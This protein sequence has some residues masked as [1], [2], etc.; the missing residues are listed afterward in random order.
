MVMKR[1]PSGYGGLLGADFIEYD[2]GKCVVELIVSK[3]HLN[4]GG[5]V[6]GGVING[7]LDIA[8]SAAVTSAMLDKAE[9]VVTLQ[10]NVNF[11]RAGKLGD[12]LITTAEIV[13]MG[14]TIINVEGEIKSAE[15][16]KLIAKA[17]GDW[18]VKSK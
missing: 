12:K 5:T 1:D 9:K 11:L 2:A 6:H 14:S 18:F 3:E 8:L 16:N 17:S 7:L 10:M 15:D 13:K 4:I